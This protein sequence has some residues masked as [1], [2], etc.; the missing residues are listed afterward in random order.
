MPLMGTPLV[1]GTARERRTRNPSLSHWPPGAPWKVHLADAGHQRGYGHRAPLSGHRMR[2]KEKTHAIF[3]QAPT[4][5]LVSA[6][7]SGAG[8]NDRLMGACACVL[9]PW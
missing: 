5:K 1:P 4:A 3:R 7:A 8:S 9:S 6:D 2:W